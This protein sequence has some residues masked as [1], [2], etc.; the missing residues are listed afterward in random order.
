MSCPHLVSL[1]ATGFVIKLKYRKTELKVM[2][3]LNNIVS[4]FLVTDQVRYTLY[5]MKKKMN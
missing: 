3:K 4:S 5:S 1:L 2:T